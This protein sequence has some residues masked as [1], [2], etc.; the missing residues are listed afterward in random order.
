MQSI[1]GRLRTSRSSLDICG[2]RGSSHAL[3]L[4]RVAA[5]LQRTVCCIVPSDEQLENLAR[6]I[7]LF[8]EVAVL[9]YPSFEIPPYT[10]LSPDPATVAQRLATLYRLQ[11]ITGPAIV[12][13]SAEAVLRRILPRTILGRHCELIITG[14]ETDLDKLTAALTAAG[15]QMCTMVQHEGDLAVRGGI[16]DIYAPATSS[17]SQGPLRLDFFGDTIESIRIFDPVTQR[18]IAEIDEAVIL[19]ASDILFPPAG[20][21]PA[22][23]KFLAQAALEYQWPREAGNEL[24]TRFLDR[25]RFTGIEFYLPLIYEAEEPVQTLFAYLPQDTINVLYEPAEITRR[26]DLV[27]DRIHANHQEALG[28]DL[29]VLPPA[30]LFLSREALR[31]E[32]SAMQSLHLCSLPDP[33]STREQVTISTGDHT[34]LGQELELHRK[35]R[36]NLAPLVD[37][38][39]SWLN[40]GERTVMACRSSRQASH[41]QEMLAEYQLPAN[42][43][44]APLDLRFQGETPSLLLVEHPLERGFDLP[45]EGLH[46]L[47][48]TEMF[49]EKK[50]RAE[51]RRKEV[52]ED[53]EP[54]AVEELTPGAF[55]VHRDHGVGLFQGLLNMEFAGQRGDFMQIEYRDGAKLYVPVDRLHWVNRYQGLTDQEPKLDQLG[56]SKWQSTK[57]KVSEAVWKVAQD[58]LDIYARR[59]LREGHAF[60]RPGELYHEL[61]Q[62]FPYDETSGQQKAIAGVLDDLGRDQPMD[63]LVCGDVGYGKTEVAARAA[64]KVIED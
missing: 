33:D 7:R 11:N 9:S 15:Y 42:Q 17:A 3:F 51:G 47:S 36:G 23:K 59:A 10:P 43:V 18:S 39:K 14:E 21:D 58:L 49:G 6:D 19:P 61:E 34:L 55:V 27:W 30:K 52:P 54:L 26:I 62:S 25:I 64:F 31:Q 12:L 32:E 4:A 37:R 57:N 40:H 63:R 28:K 29:A 50:L 53:L 56:S 46:F 60:S 5:E 8:S 41:L 20:S 24:I 22:W 16:I 48:A 35:K 13:T 2:L 45:A 44:H 38:L 1:L